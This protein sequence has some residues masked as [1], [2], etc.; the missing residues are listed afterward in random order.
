MTYYSQYKQDQYVHENLLKDVSKGFFVDIGAYDG[1]T[2]GSNSLFFEQLGW[3]GICI[4]PNPAR[5]S[6]LE[7][8]RKCT[9]LN[10]AIADTVGEASFLQIID[11]IDTLSGLVD[12]FSDAYKQELERVME[13][14]NY[15]HEYVTVKTER[16][17]NLV[18]STRIIDYLS[19]DTEGNEL[20]ILQTI[21]FNKHDI[22]IM[23][24][25]NNKHDDRFIRFFSDKPY[26]LVA[27]L[28]CDEVYAK[29]LI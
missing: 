4:E 16:F 14:N 19:I 9:C 28:G 12:A 15:R 13:T 23:T 8:N 2:Q 20:S 1:I 10:Y 21:D 17:D 24:I 18:P 25:E 5:F 11:E 26:D 22:R 3:E 7:Q 29:R 6:L 27:R